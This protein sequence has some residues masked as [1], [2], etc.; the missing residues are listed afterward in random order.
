M[1][2]KDIERLFMVFILIISVFYGFLAL[3]TDMLGEDELPYYHLAKD[4]TAGGYPG[5]VKYFLA[6]QA[7]HPMLSLLAVPFFM[8]FGA[9]L[10]I[11]KMLSSLFFPLTILMVYL[12]GKKINFWFGLFS[13]LL[14]FSIS[15][16]NHLS[17][18][19]YL[20]VPGAF[21]SALV[22][23]ML[24]KTKSLSDAIIL[25]IT[26]GLAFFVKASFLIFVPVIFFY[27]LYSKKDIKLIL[28][29]LVSF[30]VMLLPFMIRNIVLF[31]YPFVDGFNMLFVEPSVHPEWMKAVIG[32][33][34]AVSMTPTFYMDSVGIIVFGLA[35]F[36]VTYLFNKKEVGKNE[37]SVLSG[38][39]AVILFTFLLFTF[40]FLT[41]LNRQ[42]VIEQRHLMI[43]FPQMALLGGYFLWK[44]KE[45]NKYTTIFIAALLLFSIY[46]GATY[47]IATSNMQRFTDPYKE[48]LYWM[49]DNANEGDL[50]FTTYLGSFNYYSGRYGIWSDIEEFPEMMTTAGGERIHEILSKNYNISYILIWKATLAPEYIIP[51]SNIWGT[52]TYNFLNNLMNDP[53]NFELVFENQEVFIFR[54]K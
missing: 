35:L 4:I 52:F 36:G 21:F 26:A 14:L 7:L 40:T 9:E 16:L 12:L 49:R 2:V 28:T 34:A 32:Q 31:N 44:L 1:D 8:I 6:P 53:N 24:I 25:G 3:N 5:Y 15:M 37:Y 51:Q 29:S 42:V 11:V 38:S 20:D 17:L 39:F 18:L 27:G 45:L 23:Y 33:I 22:L 46:T 41:G 47:A 19:A 43:M 30:F 48:S 10:G 54:L 50:T 13:A